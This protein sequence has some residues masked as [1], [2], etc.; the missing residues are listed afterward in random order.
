MTLY[1]EVQAKGQA[2][3]DAVIDRDRLPEHADRPN[4]PYVEAI[5]KEIFR[6]HPVSPFG[7]VCFIPPRLW[8]I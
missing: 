4:L 5:T 6:W 7:I 3:L 1:P 8:V 2:Q